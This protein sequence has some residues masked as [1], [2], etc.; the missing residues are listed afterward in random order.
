MIR[1]E[2]GKKKWNTVILSMTTAKKSEFG[3]TSLIDIILQ[4]GNFGTV[5]V[6]LEKVF[7]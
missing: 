7:V 1:F 5:Y 6:V 3:N 4:L 2:V